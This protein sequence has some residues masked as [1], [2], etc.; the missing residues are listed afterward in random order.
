MK[1]I[2]ACYKYHPSYCI[3]ENFRCRAANALQYGSWCESV[4]R[5]EIAKDLF[6]S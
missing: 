5:D 3:K 2:S 6:G 4:W 1:L